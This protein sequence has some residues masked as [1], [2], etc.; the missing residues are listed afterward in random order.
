MFHFISTLKVQPKSMSI[1][2]GR[3]SYCFC[4]VRA[5]C[6]IDSTGSGHFVLSL[7]LSVFITACLTQIVVCIIVLLFLP[8]VRGEAGIDTNHRS[9]FSFFVTD[10]VSQ[11]SPPPTSTFLNSLISF[12]TPAKSPRSPPISVSVFSFYPPL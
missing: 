2:H 6:S 1:F 10:P 4:G 8:E 9:L 11:L 12:P 7:L 3:M 5:L